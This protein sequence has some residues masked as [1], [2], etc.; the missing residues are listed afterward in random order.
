MLHGH[1]LPMRLNR[2]VAKGYGYCAKRIG[3]SRNDVHVRKE[4]GWFKS[5][6]PQEIS[7]EVAT[8]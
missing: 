6:D 5:L 8:V 7:G 3:L 4:G 2:L 1:Q